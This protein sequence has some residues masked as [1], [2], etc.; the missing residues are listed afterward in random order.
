MTSTQA[1]ILAL[2]ALATSSNGVPHASELASLVVPQVSRMNAL[3]PTGVPA[4]TTD[5]LIEALTDTQQNVIEKTYR[6]DGE[7]IKDLVS[8]EVGKDGTVLLPVI[9]EGKLAPIWN[10]EGCAF[11]VATLGDKKQI[12]TTTPSD[13]PPY[14]Q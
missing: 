7:P 13:L 6:W 8:L 9:K 1:Q 11:K 14:P 3:S 2:A 12:L 4:L 10:I 5:F